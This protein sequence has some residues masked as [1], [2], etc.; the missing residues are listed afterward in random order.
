MMVWCFVLW[1]GRVSRIFSTRLHKYKGWSASFLLLLISKTG[2]Q[3]Y[4]LIYD[5]IPSLLFISRE[6]PTA[7][8]QKEVNL[9]GWQKRSCIC[10]GDR[11]RIYT[12]PKRKVAEKYMMFPILVVYLVCKLY[13][14]SLSSFWFTCY[15]AKGKERCSTILFTTALCCNCISATLN[16]QTF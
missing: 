15:G 10:C 4:K 2:K 11:E 7:I 13:S 8:N 6:I 5:T 16:Q 1:L 3:N 14:I 9:K 12:D